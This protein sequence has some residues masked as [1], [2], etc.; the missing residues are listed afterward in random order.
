M[1]TRTGEVEGGA[2][3]GN[4]QKHRS[5]SEAAKELLTL[6]GAPS[7][8]EGPGEIEDQQRAAKHGE[9]H[10]VPG[11]A[12]EACEHDEKREA[13]DAKSEPKEARDPVGDVL[14]PGIGANR[15][16]N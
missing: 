6:L 1:A 4:C 16:L 12:P 5:V 15:R 7:V 2:G 9:T 14:A 13:R 8:I 10:H 3:S 11:A